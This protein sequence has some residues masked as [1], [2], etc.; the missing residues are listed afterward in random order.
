MNFT[1]KIIGLLFITIFFINTNANAQEGYIAEIRLFAGNFAPRG[2]AFCNGQILPISQYQALFSLIGCQYGGDCRTTFALPDLRGRVTIH[3]GNSTG[4]GLSPYQLG[5]KGGVEKVQLLTSEIPSHTHLASGK[6]N[7]NF[8]APF[9]GGAISNPNG[10]YLSG[11]NGV[12]IYTNSAPNVELGNGSLDIT[13][14]TTGGNQGHENIQPYCVVN[15]IIALQ[16]IF[17]PRN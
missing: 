3:S 15:Y 16:G 13:V 8:T 9:G 10:A 5:Q 6:I 14:G 1:K 2:W 4:P 7:A 12:D 17:P 11:K